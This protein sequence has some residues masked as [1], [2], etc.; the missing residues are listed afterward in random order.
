MMPR[1]VVEGSKAS[2]YEGLPMFATKR[3]FKKQTLFEDKDMVDNT[4]YHN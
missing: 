3:G 2:V 1:F 4:V